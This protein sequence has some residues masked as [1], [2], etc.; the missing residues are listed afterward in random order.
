M[1]NVEPVIINL[2]EDNDND[3]ELNLEQIEK[4]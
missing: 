2:D 4:N 3:T 1:S